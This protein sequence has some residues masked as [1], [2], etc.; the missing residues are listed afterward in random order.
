MRGDALQQGLLD[1]HGEQ[2]EV[3]YRLGRHSLEEAETVRLRL[4]GSAI[5]FEHRRQVL[6]STSTHGGDGRANGSIE[7]FAAQHP[8]M[9]R[10]H[11][12]SPT[13]DGIQ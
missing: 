10:R 1:H 4:K 3:L 12:Q 6:R 7:F 13:G 5:V 2:A 9:P 11:F 8:P